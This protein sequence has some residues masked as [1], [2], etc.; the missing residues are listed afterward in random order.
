M[1]KIAADCVSQMYFTASLMG[2]QHRSYAYFMYSKCNVED[3]F[4]VHSFAALMMEAV[5]TSETSVN[6]NL[7]PWHYIPE[8]SKLHTH[9]S[10]IVNLCGEA[11]V[12]C[13][14]W[15]ESLTHCP[16]DG[17]SMHLWNVGST[18]TWLHGTA[19]QK[20]VNLTWDYFWQSTVVFLKG[21]WLALTCAP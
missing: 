18:S 8:D 14:R 21:K 2:L 10:H 12:R 6:I 17:G 1:G 15:F 11:T 7:T 19:S 20:T 13:I 16:D 5:H 3:S 4:R 9:Q